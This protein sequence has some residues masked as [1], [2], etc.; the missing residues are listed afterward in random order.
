MANNDIIQI[1]I[2]GKLVGISGLENVMKAMAADYASSSDEEIANQMLERLFV[3]N[4][5]PN[6]ARDAYAQSL[7]LEF[8]KYLGQV[9]KETPFPGLNVAVLGPGCAQCDLMETDVREIMAE[10]KLAADLIHISDIR[11][12][13]RYGVMG[14]PALVINGKVA[15]VGQAPNRNKIRE[16]LSDALKVS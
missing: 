7:V 11:E 8:R 4:Y 13:A 9:D 2:K 3:K 14:L 12:I 15:C 5:I 10:M 6:S 16:W 1:R